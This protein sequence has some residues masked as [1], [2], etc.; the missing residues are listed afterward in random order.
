MITDLPTVT[1]IS[2]SFT[3]KMEAKI[4]WN[5]FYI[6]VTLCILTCNVV[7]FIFCVS[8]A[9]NLH[10]KRDVAR[11]SCSKSAQ[12]WLRRLPNSNSILLLRHAWQLYRHGL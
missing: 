3:Y 5:D 10:L 1:N 4:N 8:M 6:I 2:K 7:F 12:H 9:E 11:V